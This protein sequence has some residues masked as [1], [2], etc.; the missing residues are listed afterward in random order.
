M[1]RPAFL[2]RD[3]QDTDADQDHP[4]ARTPHRDLRSARRSRDGRTAL[5][6]RSGRSGAGG[7][8]SARGK[9]DRLCGAALLPAS[10]RTR[11]AD[12]RG[13]ARRHAGVARRSDRG[14]DRRRHRLCHASDDVA[15]ASR[16]DRN[17]ARSA[18]QCQLPRPAT[19]LGCVYLW[20]ESGRPPLL[21]GRPLSAFITVETI[22]VP[23]R[24]FQADKLVDAV[25]TADVPEVF[26][27]LLHPAVS[28]CMLV[29]QRRRGK[30]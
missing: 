5:H 11:A 17:P 4:V 27:H 3:E 18:C 8:T 15:R 2:F 21:P 13:G 7:A 10:F 14:R 29:R 24:S 23:R 1:N 25:S 9:P 20:V 28:L 26:R 6:A 16:R 12:E 22:P 30:A 19:C